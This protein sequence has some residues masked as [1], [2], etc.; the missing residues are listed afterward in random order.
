MKNLRLFGASAVAVFMLLSGCADYE[1]Y[2]LP[3]KTG[4]TGTT[5]EVTSKEFRTEP[6]AG[7]YIIVFYENAAIRGVDQLVYEKALDLMRHVG[8]SEENIGFVYAHSIL[9]FSASLDATMVEVMRANPEVAYVEQDQLITMNQYD[10]N[11]KPDNPGG[12]NGG[13][14]DTEPDPAQTT[15]AGITRHG[16][17]TNVSGKRAWIIDS[18]IDMDHND[19]NVSGSWHQSKGFSRSFL[20]GKEDKNPDDQHGH[21]T[22]VAGTV[23]AINNS[24]GVVGIAAGVEVVAVRVLDRRGSGTYSA[25]IKGIDYVAAE[26]SSG[27][28]ANMSL[29]GGYSLALNQ[30]VIAAS[31]TCPFAIA[32]GNSGANA[33]NYSPA[34]ANALG[35]YTV[36]AMTASD[37]WASFSNYGNP[38][39]DYCAV[40]V[41]VLSCYKGNGYTT[42][43]GT[44]MAAPHVCGLL[45]AN[46]GSLNTDGYVN[47]DPD[48]V[49]DPIAH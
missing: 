49:D 44:S 5:A 27:D 37:N 7:Q 25:V 43:S 46:G 32:A 42:M 31:Q 12:G 33:A 18:G 38:P 8:A 45:L 48:T 3:V 29:G 41:N 14:G 11:A 30:A 19:L 2:P 22:H 1:N 24:I 6:I 4:G 40:G 9:G 28:A 15:P 26:A 13:G 34:S 20:G 10:A 17:A 16:G 23:G 36:S 35:I 47:N 39:V 21:G